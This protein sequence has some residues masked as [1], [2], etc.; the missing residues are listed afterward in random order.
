M[1]HRNQRMTN[2]RL[3]TEWYECQ[4][5]GEQFPRRDMIVQRGLTVCVVRCKDMPGRA[6]LSEGYPL[7]TEEA[8]PDLPEDNQEI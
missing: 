7:R 8:V 3:G 5:C 4:R 2:N 6:A 1:L